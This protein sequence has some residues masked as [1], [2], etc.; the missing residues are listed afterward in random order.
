M[1]NGLKEN[2]TLLRILGPTLMTAPLKLRRPQPSLPSIFGVWVSSDDG[3]DSGDGDGNPNG[4]ADSDRDG[5]DVVSAVA[6]G[7][8]QQTTTAPPHLALS[9]I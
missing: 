4:P 8:L 1:D 7:G 5:A 3:D 2:N 6:F 9:I